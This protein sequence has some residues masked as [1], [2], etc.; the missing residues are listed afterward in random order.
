MQLFFLLG[1]IFDLSSACSDMET[2][3][4]VYVNPQQNL[5]FN[6]VTITLFFIN[7]MAVLLW[8]VYRKTWLFY[9]YLAFSLLN[10]GIFIYSSW[11]REIYYP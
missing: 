6:W 10:I 4:K 1:A 3:N 8:L 5:I 2:Y 9:L 11:T 7:I